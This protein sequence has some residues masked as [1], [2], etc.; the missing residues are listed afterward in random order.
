LVALIILGESEAGAGIYPLCWH[1]TQ[2][3]AMPVFEYKQ[4]IIG[5]KVLSAGGK[6]FVEE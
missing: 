4:C 2:L 6:S 1:Y 3:S 5:Q